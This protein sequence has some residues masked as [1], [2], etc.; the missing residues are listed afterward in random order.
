MPTDNFGFEHRQ[1]EVRRKVSVICLKYMDR[2]RLSRQQ[3]ANLVQLSRSQLKAI[4]NRESN[5]TL[6]VLI[7]I[8]AVT[9]EKIII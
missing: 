9:G 6:N 4:I 7:K 3:F 1:A 2:N 5:T 8:S